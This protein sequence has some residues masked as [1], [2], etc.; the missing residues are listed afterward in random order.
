MGSLANII[1]LSDCFSNA[2]TMMIRSQRTVQIRSSSL[3]IVHFCLHQT[4]PFPF[5]LC[6]LLTASSSRFRSPPV[7]LSGRTATRFLS[8]ETDRDAA[9]E[10]AAAAHAADDEHDGVRGRGGGPGDRRSGRGREPEP[11]PPPP[12]EAAE[13]AAG[14]GGHAVEER[15]GQ[16]SEEE[17]R[18]LRGGGDRFL[19]DGLRPLQAPPGPRPR[20]VHV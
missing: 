9:E 19:F 2:I 12:P 10:A 7:H 11:P 16:G 14:G 17:L 1:S 8:E 15:R 5:A 20:H 4:P 3:L 13:P 6:G 18:E